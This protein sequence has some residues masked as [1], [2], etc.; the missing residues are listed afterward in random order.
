MI[1]KIFLILIVL[2]LVFTHL[3]FGKKA[4]VLS[5]V[6]KPGAVAVQG[7][8]LYVTEGESVHIYSLNPFKYI[9]K[10]GKKGE[11]PAEFKRMPYLIPFPEYVFINSP[12]K[13]QFFSAAGDFK[14]EVKLPFHYFF[15]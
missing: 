12:G 10:F 2:L 11:G 7:N 6:V 13:I 3:V 14:K 15:I 9:K 4:V 1:K 5:E 8:R